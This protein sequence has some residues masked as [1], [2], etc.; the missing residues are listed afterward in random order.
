MNLTGR[1]RVAPGDD[2]VLIWVPGTGLSRFM[3]LSAAL[4]AMAATSPPALLAD[5]SRPSRLA[6]P[7]VRLSLTR[8]PSQG[9][10]EQES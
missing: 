5:S 9:T 10:T 2:N 4:G 7:L 1:N 6:A 8:N 3:T